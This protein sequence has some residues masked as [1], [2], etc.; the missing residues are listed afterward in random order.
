MRGRP[1]FLLVLSC[2]ALATRLPGTNTEIGKPRLARLL[3]RDWLTDQDASPLRAWVEN[4][5]APAL[6]VELRQSPPIEDDT[7]RASLQQ[8]YA[9]CAIEWAA[10]R[11]RNGQPTVLDA[12][13]G[14]LV[15]LVRVGT[16]GVRAELALPDGSPAIFEAALPSRGRLLLFHLGT[17]LLLGVLVAFATR[18]SSRWPTSSA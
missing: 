18:R 10:A 1:R 12:R 8:Q 11:S 3:V 2:V 5:R 6:Q 9:L 16:E 17:A 14:T 13:R 7:L 15:A 4:G